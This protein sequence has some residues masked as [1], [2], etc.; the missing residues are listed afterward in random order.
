M[1]S[2]P[3]VGVCNHLTIHLSQ[4]RIQILKTTIIVGIFVAG[5]YWDLVFSG[6]H[7]NHLPYRV[8]PHLVDFRNTHYLHTAEETAK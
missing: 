7:H 1:M 8:D 5:S 2:L 4:I 3:V 6:E